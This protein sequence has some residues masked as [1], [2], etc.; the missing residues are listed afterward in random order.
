MKP[1][2]WIET[3]AEEDATAELAR[4]YQKEKDFRTGKV[5]HILK[6]HSLNPP[7]LADH[8]RMYHHVMHGESGL[9]LAEREMV[10]V[11][12]SAINECHY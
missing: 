6:V 1:V 5:D 3:I 10:A 7:S 9:T 8:A 11:V 2:A 4:L 12:V